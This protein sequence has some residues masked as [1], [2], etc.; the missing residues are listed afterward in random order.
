MAKVAGNLTLRDSLLAK[1]SLR[2]GFHG[3]CLNNCACLI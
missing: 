1:L 3:H 2:G